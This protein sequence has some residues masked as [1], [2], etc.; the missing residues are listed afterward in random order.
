MT[1]TRETFERRS[2]EMRQ[3][4]TQKKERRT[5]PS[6]PIA[7]PPKLVSDAWHQRCLQDVRDGHLLTFKQIA[8][9]T[10]LSKETIRQIFMKADGVL[11]IRTEYRVPMCVF[12]SVMKTFFVRKV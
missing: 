2:A 4:M 8:S 11:K 1:V 5:A 3:R 12:D 9:K 6:F 7:E 10:G